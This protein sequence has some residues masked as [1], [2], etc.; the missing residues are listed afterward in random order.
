LI[1]SAVAAEAGGARDA[2]RRPLP[3]GDVLSSL[4]NS[5]WQISFSSCLW[6][7]EQWDLEAIDLW[8]T[9]AGNAL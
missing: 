8:H 5:G 6:A 9:H 7:I 3:H 1:L 4:L 2:A